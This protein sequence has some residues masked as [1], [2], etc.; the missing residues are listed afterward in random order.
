MMMVCC[1]SMISQV[2]KACAESVIEA[3]K[4]GIPFGEKKAKYKASK[5]PAR[6]IAAKK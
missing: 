3:Y 4:K 1:L 5:G 2:K 6:K